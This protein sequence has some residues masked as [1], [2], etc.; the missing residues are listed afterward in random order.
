MSLEGRFGRAV[1]VEP[2]T[3][4]PCVRLAGLNREHVLFMY[5]EEWDTGMYFGL[6]VVFPSYQSGGGGGRRRALL[7]TAFSASNLDAALYNSKA[8]LFG[9]LDVYG[10][11]EVLYS[12]I[13]SHTLGSGPAPPAPM[14]PGTYTA[15]DWFQPNLFSSFT[16]PG[17]GSSGA[18]FE[19]FEYATMVITFDANFASALESDWPMFGPS[20]VENLAYAAPSE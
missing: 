17:S 6:Q 8:P 7:Q 2:L 14:P 12:S 11:H 19:P 16:T 3:P 4:T 9:P 20:Y 13:L 1:R 18:P 10:G 15:F 5:I